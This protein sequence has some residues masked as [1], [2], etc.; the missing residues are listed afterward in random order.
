MVLWILG[1]YSNS[2][3]VILQI[4]DMIKK[5]LGEIPI[6]DSEMR[7]IEKDLEPKTETKNLSKVFIFF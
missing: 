2:S 1:E 7:N 6:V 3:S 5:S 4:V